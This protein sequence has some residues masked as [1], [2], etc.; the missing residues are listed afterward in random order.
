MVRFLR[1]V[2]IQ[3]VSLASREQQQ[4][5]RSNRVSVVSIQLVSLAS[6]EEYDCLSVRNSDGLVSIQLVSLAS[7]EVRLSVIS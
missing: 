5:T 3:L 1:Q 7:R 4:T 2:S 6:R